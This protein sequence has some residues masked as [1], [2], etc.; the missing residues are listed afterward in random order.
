[1]K[2]LIIVDTLKYIKNDCFQSQLYSAIQRGYDVKIVELY[3]LQL[4]N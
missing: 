3:P 1:M 4:L 2:C